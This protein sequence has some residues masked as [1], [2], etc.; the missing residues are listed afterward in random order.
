MAVYWIAIRT[1]RELQGRGGEWFDSPWR[2]NFKS[3]QNLQENTSTLN[4]N[5]PILRSPLFN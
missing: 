3:W 5:N 4:E 2:L 1:R